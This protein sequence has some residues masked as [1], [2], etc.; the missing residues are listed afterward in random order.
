[1]FWKSEEPELDGAADEEALDG[2]ADEA[3]DGAWL[4][5]D[6]LKVVVAALEV[7]AGAEDEDEEEAEAK[8]AFG[9]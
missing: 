7:E 4:E 2:A 1:M 5:E 9:T 6:G 3:L 8:A